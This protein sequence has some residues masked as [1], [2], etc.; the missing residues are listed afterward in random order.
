MQ[1]DGVKPNEI[2]FPC[3]IKA[4]RNLGALV[5]GR[6]AHDLIVR[7]ECESDTAI[8]NSLVDM[9]TRCGSLPDAISVSIRLPRKNAELCSMLRGYSS[10]K[11][12]EWVD[13]YGHRISDPLDACGRSGD[14]V[15]STDKLNEVVNIFGR[16]GQLGEAKLVL[17]TMPRLG[18]DIGWT[19]LLTA[20]Q[21]HGQMR[22][23]RQCFHQLTPLV[24]CSD[25]NSYPHTT[26][27]A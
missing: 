23:G 12:D 7:Y 26:S 6:L 19:S 24:S 18:D 15:I 4:C 2:I 13:E 16:Q 10:S 14:S 25:R 5:L 8:G 21:I 17:Q 27:E 9:Y 22:I 1:K 11:G 20:C 3:V